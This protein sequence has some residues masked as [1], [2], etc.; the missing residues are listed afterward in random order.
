MA[1]P[2]NISNAPAPGSKRLLDETDAGPRKEASTKDVPAIYQPSDEAVRAAV[3]ACLPRMSGFNPAAPQLQLRDP[4][5]V[6]LPNQ[7][8]MCRRLYDKILPLQFYAQFVDVKHEFVHLRVCDLCWA[9]DSLGLNACRLCSKPIQPDL[10]GVR[11]RL[12][13]YAKLAGSDRA[14]FLHEFCAEVAVFTGEMCIRC[15][16]LDLPDNSSLKLFVPEGGRACPKCRSECTACGTQLTLDDMTKRYVSDMSVAT[17]KVFQKITPES[18]MDPFK[19]IDQESTGTGFHEACMPTVDRAAGSVIVTAAQEEIRRAAM[20][21]EQATLREEVE[22]KF[23][24]A[25]R[26]RS[27]Q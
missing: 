8:T 3:A 1:E 19:V 9:D 14:V 4:I 26:W 2:S 23:T 20:E 6:S 18:E 16:K 11:L 17:G 24:E 27:S 10:T 15:H 7:C 5:P 13:R 25:N 12:V 21:K 22:K